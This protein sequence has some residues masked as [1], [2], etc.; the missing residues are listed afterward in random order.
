[1]INALPSEILVQVIDALPVRIFWKDVES[2]FLGCNQRFADDAGVA[3]P[4]EFIGK[5]D[6]YFYHPDQAVAFRAD[7]TEILLTG[8]AKLGIEERL[9]HASG[10][11]L[12]IETNKMPMHDATG[13]IVGVIGAYHDITARKRAEIESGA[14]AS[15][16]G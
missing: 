5:S 8:Q 7:D 9:T 12:W 1:M 16:P 6:F 3:D 2:R 14:P 10:D 13:R 4:M 15:R 11:I